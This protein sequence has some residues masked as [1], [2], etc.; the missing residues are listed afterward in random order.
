[1]R[2]I[3]VPVYG[4][5]H[6]NTNTNNNGNGNGRP[7]HYGG[8]H[9]MRG[10]FRGCPY[11]RWGAPGRQ[12]KQMARFIKDVTIP[13]G[14]QVPIGHRVVKT[15]R[16]RNESDQ[17][18]PQGI[19]LIHVGGDMLGVSQTIPVESVG[20]GQEADI[21]IEIIAPPA[22]GRYNSFWR[23]CYSD[24]Q[25][26]GQR[27]WADITAVDAP[28]TTAMD[29]N[30]TTTNTPVPP[31]PQPQQDND[32]H[33]KQQEEEEPITQE[34]KQAVQQLRDMGFVGDILPVLRKNRGNVEASLTELLASL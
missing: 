14:T 4:N 33:N 18:W 8:G 13:D 9:F 27:M 19:C 12:Q 28:V 24:G 7:N 5:Y 1:M 30:T 34:E 16:I 10:G 26:F 32:N 29:T 21:S 22:A 3:L 17:A 20:A 11:N 6:N 31:E 25:R 15:W 23:L 2:Q